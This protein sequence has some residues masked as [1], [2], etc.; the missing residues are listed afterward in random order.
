M[1][2]ATPQPAPVIPERDPEPEMVERVAR[3]ICRASVA[4]DPFFNDDGEDYWEDYIPEARAAIALCR[5]VYR[6]QALE[7]AAKVKPEES[8]THYLQASGYTFG[9]DAALRAKAAAI[10][11]M[12][13]EGE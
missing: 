6:R 7:E 13:K 2:P 9:W 3:E 12:I 5:P 4:D 8:E 11:A 10:R 1:T